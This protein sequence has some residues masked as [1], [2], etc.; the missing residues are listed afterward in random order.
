MAVIILSY[1]PWRLRL[2]FRFS[3]KVDRGHAPSADLALDGIAVGEGGLEAVE[4]VRSVG[5][6]SWL[7]EDVVLI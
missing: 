6:P 5:G 2:C 4:S 3:A 1:S 7:E